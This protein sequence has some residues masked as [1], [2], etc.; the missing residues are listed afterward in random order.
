MFARMH[1]TFIPGN[2]C[3]AGCSVNDGVNIKSN[4]NNVNSFISYEVHDEKMDSS[5]YACCVGRN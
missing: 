4:D 3:F 2:V 5:S 1:K